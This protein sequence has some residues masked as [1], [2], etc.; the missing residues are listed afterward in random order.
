MLL[1][2]IGALLCLAVVQEPAAAMRH[3]VVYREEGRFAGWPANHGIWSWGDEILVGFS[4]GTYK[5]RGPFHHIDK[6]RAEEFLLA[7]SR[8]GGATW[9]LEEPRPRGILAGTPGMRHGTMPPGLAP[10]QPTEL[11]EPIHFDRPDFAMTIRMENSNNG[12][13]RFFFSYDRGKK[14]QGPYGLPLFDQ[15]GVM[16][17]TDYIVDGRSRCTLFLTASKANSREGRPFCARTDDG[18]LTWRFLSFIGPE[19]VGYAIMP[20]SARLSPLD[21]VTTIRRQDPPRSW[22]DA[23]VSRDDG[24]TWK[25]LS[26]PEPDTGEGNPPSLLRLPDNRLCLI[27]GSRRQPFGIY[28]R[29]SGDQGKTWARPIALRDDAGGRD[30]GYVRS[31]VRPDGK[32]VAVYYYQDQKGPTRYLAATIWNQGKS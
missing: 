12:I 20:S 19:P 26:T 29:L 27:Y 31:I 23:Y 2:W 1:H 10:D 18:G 5:D 22:I 30:I 8:D 7:R 16:G 32:V 13:S 25:F 28:A 9:S 14:W 3:I 6:E 15:K 17:R 4:R 11:H 24:S 21:L